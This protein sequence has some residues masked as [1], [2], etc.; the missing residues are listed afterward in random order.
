MTAAADHHFLFGLLAL[1]NGI[2]NQG[3]LVAAFQAWALDRSRSLADH[4]EARGDLTT[5]RRALLEALASVHL[6]A[7]GGEVERSLAAVSAGK[8]T[9]ERL[10]RIGDPE[11]NETLGHIPSAIGPTEDDIDRTTS[12]AV[13]SAT[14]NGQRFRVLRPHARGGLGAV[15][16]ALDAELNREV[17][18][19]QILDHHA[20]DPISRERFLIEAAITGGLEHPGI[21]P[22]YGLGTYGNGRP[23][24]AMRFVRGDS[25][26]EAVDTFHSD[27]SLKADPGRRSLELRKLL[28]RFTDVCDAID[29]AHSRGVLHRDIKPGNVIVGKHGETLVVDW[30]L[31]KVVGK[32][33]PNSGERSLVPSS[34]SGTSKTLP[35]MALGTPAY[36]SPEQAAGDLDALGPRS[37]VYSLGATLYCLLT[38]SPPFTESDIGAV[39]HAV[40]QGKFPPP[41]VLD[42]SL[43][44]SLE[45]ICLKAMAT[46]PNERYPSC[47]ALTDDLERWMADEPVSA[48]REPWSEHLRRWMRHRRTAVAAAAAALLVALAGLAAV[49]AVQARANDRLKAKNDALAASQRETAS[50]RDQKGKEAAKAVAINRFLIDKILVQ[51][52]PANSKVDEKLTVLQALDNAAKGMAGSFEGQPQVEAEIRTAVG[53]TYSTLGAHEKARDQHGA[54]YEL[55]VR[56]NGERN[57]ATL[58]A[59]AGYAHDLDALGRSA[60]AQTI[61]ESVVTTDRQVLGPDHLDTLIALETLGAALWSQAKYV[62]A[63]A[64]FREAL[65]IRRRVQGSEQHDALNTLTNLALTIRTQGKYDEAEGMHRESLEAQRRV[66]GPEHPETLSALN[67]LA[68]VVAA[69]GKYGEAE[70]MNRESLQIRH[71]VSGPEHPETLTAINNLAAAVWS[72]GRYGEAADLLREL[73]A[74]RRRVSG[75]E[76]PETLTAINNLASALLSQARYRE[77]EAIERVLLQARRRVQGPEHPH[78]L[79]AL[80]NLGL[81]LDLQGRG[82]EAE[83]MEREALRTLERVSGPGSPEAL[84]A[85]HYLIE[86]LERQG[87]LSDALRCWSPKASARFQS[88]KATQSPRPL[89]GSLL[90]ARGRLLTNLARAGEAESLIREALA[91]RRQALP[92]GH[93]RTGEAES[94]LGACLGAQGRRSEAEPLLRSGAAAMGTA[95]VYRWRNGVERLVVFYETSSLPVPASAWRLKLMDAD[96]PSQPFVVQP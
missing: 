16:V 84:M 49:V 12:F 61:L 26:K 34:S 7:H 54:A 29:Y 28:R 81:I 89:G 76:H 22:V 91:I 14:S 95:P 11:I 18:L 86:N 39:L 24:Y 94:T 43:S 87:R 57:P 71:R 83:T 30:G 4:L 9:R 13:G 69:Q 47:R 8:S 40:R 46:A 5:A 96:F 41:R 53:D 59:R 67:N 51:A 55:L 27:G 38:G 44:P 58:K 60:E 32:A 33:E 92:P 64:V 6:E 82:R 17:A 3:Q 75:P 85:L 77:A 23:F 19:K 70:A 45:A 88:V 73:V 31:A 42:A 37:D 1:Q 35:G 2:I 50:E 25:L 74:V 93:W 90:L 21:V 80:G 10:A 68:T 66:L 63:E 79:L 52:D 56:E 72:Q 48:Y 65:T 62:E 78:T 15:F 36:M 20:D